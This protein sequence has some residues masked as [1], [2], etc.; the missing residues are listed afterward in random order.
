MYLV[1]DVVNPAASRR[2]EGVEDLVSVYCNLTYSI[3]LPVFVGME[4]A[5]R[6]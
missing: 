2:V 4:A 1:S 6:F 3:H 5:K